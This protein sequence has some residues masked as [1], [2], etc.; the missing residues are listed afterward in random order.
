MADLRARPAPLFPIAHPDAPSQPLVQFRDRPVV[1]ADAEVAQPA[2]HVLPQLVQPIGHR[3]PPASAG[4]FLHPV[5][6]GH[7]LLVQP[8]DLAPVDGEAQEAAFAHSRHL[9]FGRVEFE[10]QSSFQVARQTLHDPFSGS[11]AFD[12]N[13]HVVGV[14]GEAVASPFEFMIEF[15]EQDIG[16]ERR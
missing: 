15:V 4:E 7:Q 1:L 6:E 13:D 12:Q 11:L 14:T 8:A 16:Q 9:A 2:P 3:Y 10:L 5:L